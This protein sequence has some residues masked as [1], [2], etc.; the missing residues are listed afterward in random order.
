MFILVINS[1]SNKRS[2]RQTFE[3]DYEQILE[4]KIITLEKEN[5]NSKLNN[6][7]LFIGNDSL[8]K[9]TLKNFT[10]QKKLFFYFSENTCAPCIDETIEIIKKVFPS[11]I[12]DERIVFISPDYPVRFRDD[13]H[14]KKLLTLERHKLGIP[15]EITEVP[16]FFILNDKLEIESIHIVNKTKFFKTEKYLQKIAQKL[17]FR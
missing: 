15:L 3:D 10:S 13:F 12:H 14:K 6:Q 9:K 2:D 16:F 1:C 17:G 11:Y 5:I 8:N 7:Y 4:S